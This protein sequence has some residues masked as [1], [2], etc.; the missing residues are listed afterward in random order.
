[1]PASSVDELAQRKANFAKAHAEIQHHKKKELNFYHDF[2]S[3]LRHGK[4]NTTI[5]KCNFIKL[6]EI[7][8]I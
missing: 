1:M 7:N 3:F 5:F 4:Y 8:L 2:E 6:N